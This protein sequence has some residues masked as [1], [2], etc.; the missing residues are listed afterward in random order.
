[1]T[2]LPAAVFLGALLAGHPAAAETVRVCAVESADKGCHFRGEGAIQAAVDHAADGDVIR[3]DPGRY[4]PTSVRDVAFQDIIARGFVVVSNKRLVIEGHVGTVLDGAD[5]VPSIAFVLRDAEVTFRNLEIRDFRWEEEED[6][7]YDGHGIFAIDS[8]V[9]VSDVLMR[10][11][12]KMGL[13]GRGTSL[14]EATRLRLLDGHLGIW[15]EEWSQAHV[16]DSVIANGDSAGIATYDDSTLH[17]INSVVA[18]NTDDGIFA[19]D[20]SAIVAVRSIITNNAPYGANAQG[21]G[22][23]TVRQSVLH[24]T[25][26]QAFDT[27]LAASQLV[28]GED[29]VR[30]APPLDADWLPEANAPQ[31]VRDAAGPVIGLTGTG[32]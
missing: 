17:V 32:R 11:I 30:E 4:V 29:V 31:F 9:R 6:D 25:G 16:R 10:G 3:L 8:R 26:G 1:M 2:R 5:G 24:E 27:G 19:A 23:V 12:V 28:V 22:R 15:L 20:N 13:T 7:I 21:N 14:V 18:N